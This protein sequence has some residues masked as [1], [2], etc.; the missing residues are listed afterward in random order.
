[1]TVTSR[2]EGSGTDRRPLSPHLQ[3]YRLPLLAL[4]SITHRITGVALS[5]GMLILVWWVVAAGLGVREYATVQYFLGSPIGLIL[6]FG[7]TV[8]FYY[9][10]LN[11]IRHLVWDTGYGLT[12][13]E[14]YTSAY[15]VLGLTAALTIA[16]WIAGVMLR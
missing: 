11:G 15:I 1:M 10:L 2:T 4:M 8:A 13:P 7:W 14:A 9:H 5:L 6:L 12:L 16:T 3:I